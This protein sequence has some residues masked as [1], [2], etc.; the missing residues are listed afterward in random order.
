MNYI[1]TD[2]A[3]FAPGDIYTFREYEFVLDDYERD[4]R[5]K[6][7]CA[8]CGVE[9]YRAKLCQPVIAL[10][11]LETTNAQRLVFINGE[12]YLTGITIPVKMLESDKIVLKNIPVF[13]RGKQ[14]AVLTMDL[15]VI[16]KTPPVEFNSVI[17]R[18]ICPVDPQWIQDRIDAVSES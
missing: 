2:G 15:R 4:E 8:E 11:A 18:K 13:D 14:I 1:T 3:V 5:I 16:R 12:I 6:K 9:F 10:P 7:L 17:G